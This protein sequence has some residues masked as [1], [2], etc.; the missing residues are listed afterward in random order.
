MIQLKEQ[1][2]KN[3]F[4]SAYLFYGEEQFLKKYYLEEIQKKLIPPELQM[5][6]LTVFEGK[7]IPANQ[8]IESMEML[9]FMGDKRLVIVKNSELFTSGRKNDTELM[10]DFIPN[11]PPTSCIIF[12]EDTVDKRNKVFKLMHSKKFTV[13]CGPLKENDLLIWIKREF[14]RKNKSIDNKTGIYLIRIVGTS[15]ENLAN[16]IQK[17]I[18]Y[19]EERRDITPKDIDDICIKSL[20]AHIF[21]LV[22]AMGYKKV[23]KALEIYSNLILIKEPPIRILSML[24]RQIRLILQVKYLYDKGFGSKDISEILKQPYFVI[25]DCLKQSQLFT[26]E[27]LQEAIE[28]CLQ[29][30]IDI[31][32]GKMDGELAVE[33]LLLKNS[34]LK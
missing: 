24:T 34:K 20:D 27:K 14:N 28:D 21:D 26:M 12:V 6:N 13:E 11:I 16:E 19:V 9:P 18:D 31:K 3:I 29:T 1:L 15:M 30:D 23:D 4:Q 10:C 22:K 7:V 17:L 8:I 5:M 2:K 33:M 32:T 25:N